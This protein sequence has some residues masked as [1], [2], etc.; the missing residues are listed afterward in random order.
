[1]WLDSK[2]REIIS[3]PEDGI[4]FLRCIQHTLG[5]VY[6]EKLSIEQIKQKILEEINTKIDFYED[7][8]AGKKNVNDALEDIKTY[9]ETNFFSSDILNC[10][11]LLL[12]MYFALRS[13]FSRKTTKII[14]KL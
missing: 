7:C 11:S 9:F 4:S 6:N 12:L 2:G 3:M 1:M 14:F 5:I 10:W 13:G 8:L